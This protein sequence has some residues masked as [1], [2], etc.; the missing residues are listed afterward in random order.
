MIL[1]NLLPYREQARLAKQKQFNQMVM[2]ALIV[3]LG[4]SILIYMAINNKISKQQSR[5]QFMEK[6]LV[7]LNNRVESVENMQSERDRLL[8]RKQE[9]EKLQQQRGRSAKFLDDLNN[10][11]PEG[12]YLTA[13]RA[14]KKGY[15]L[16]GQAVSD[17]RIAM[18]METLPSTGIFIGP[19]VLKDIRK[20]DR[21]QQFRL[22]GDL[23]FGGYIDD[24]WGGQQ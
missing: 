6:E 24:E 10:V 18:F 23:P 3:G 16:E 9:V 4:L 1:I 5:N 13:L 17:N 2:L 7:D 20:G 22:E 11:V 14:T 19:I 21:V 8:E 12:V 15:T